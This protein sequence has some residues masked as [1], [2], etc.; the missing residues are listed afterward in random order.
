MSQRITPRF[1][2]RITPHFFSRATYLSLPFFAVVFCSGLIF[3]MTH[4]VL[5][6]G[7]A[8]SEPTYIRGQLEGAPYR[9]DNLVSGDVIELKL[10][11]PQGEQL[12]I[13]GMLSDGEFFNGSMMISDAS[14]TEV[15]RDVIASSQPLAFGTHLGTGTSDDRTETTYTLRIQLDEV[16]GKTTSAIDLTVRAYSV[17]RFDADTY[18]DAGD[19]VRF[20]LPMPINTSVRGNLAARI[21][22]G[23]QHY[24]RSLSDATDLY[25]LQ[26]LEG[27]SYTFS[28]SPQSPLAV[29][30]ALV[31]A[32]GN[33]LIPGVSGASG[34]PVS[35]E[36]T[37]AHNVPVFARVDFLDTSVG[38]E[39]DYT[40][41]VHDDTASDAAFSNT[42]TLGSSGSGLPTK[43][44]SVGEHTSWAL[45]Q[46]FGTTLLISGDIASQGFFDGTFTLKRDNEVVFE[47][48]VSGN[49][50]Q[51]F[52]FEIASG[53]DTEDTHAHYSLEYSYT[54]GSDPIQ[55]R[56][57]QQQ[58]LRVDADST[59][60]AGDVFALATPLIVDDSPLRLRN[61]FIAHGQF[62]E[63]G[64][65]KAFDDAFDFYRFS[66]PANATYTF[67]LESAADLDLS[68][69][70]LSDTATPI[71]PLRHSTDSDDA[72]FHA[73]TPTDLIVKIGI[74]A[75]SSVRAGL[76]DLFVDI[77]PDTTPLDLA[78]E[79]T[80]SPDISDLTLPSRSH[81][82]IVDGVPLAVKHIAPQTQE[83]V[84]ISVPR[85]GHLSVA[86]EFSGGEG[87]L[88]SQKLYRADVLIHEQTLEGSHAI[89]FT[90]ELAGTEDGTD[91]T[92]YRLVSTIESILG[93]TKSLT[94]SLNP[95]LTLYD[96]AGES[97][98]H[99][100]ALTSGEPA[101]GYLSSR[102][103]VSDTHIYDLFDEVDLY[104][105]AAQPGDS[106]VAVVQPNKYLGVTLA[107]E[108]DDGTVVA[109][110]TSSDS[111]EPA[112][113][114]F[115]ATT[116]NTFSLSVSFSDISSGYYGVYDITV[117]R[118]IAQTHTTSDDA[119]AIDYGDR[120]MLRYR[121][122]SDD[123]P[124]TRYLKLAVARGDDISLQTQS[125]A[126]VITSTD[127][128][129]SQGEILRTAHEGKDLTFFA[130]ESGTYLIK[131]TFAADGDVVL[132]AHINSD[133][134]L[135]NSSETDIS[136]NAD[137]ANES[138]YKKN[139]ADEND[140]HEDD[141]YNDGDPALDHGII[142]DAKTGGFSTYAIILASII[143]VVLIPVFIRTRR[144]TTITEEEDDSE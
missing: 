50:I 139:S 93:N 134:I 39:G 82:L 11:V 40:L 18:R 127:L 38:F 115:V 91:T 88:I 85:G 1:L 113:L 71:G 15:Y 65:I 22:G 99:A 60:D 14:G 17:R 52:Y 34:T 59:T 28:L 120:T 20:A 76:Y 125:D 133:A 80:K 114:S 112:A 26:L 119:L 132:T 48:A 92:S 58:E 143:A 44:I 47:E 21:G 9:F 94:L 117:S 129:N 124:T 141:S 46:R 30:L 131:M 23:Q 87:V 98:P 37:P 29:S 35:L 42:T 56:M 128:I 118:D 95:S 75:D 12:R 109:Q 73:D 45:N 41:S 79:I 10:S 49:E 89:P 90:V 100:M 67:T 122:G 130:S 27:A 74:A 51:P 140:V 103:E 116:N 31:D 81:D 66:L 135:D 61:N 110:S 43:I 57:T 142:H 137:H 70:L 86:G 8:G 78:H 19:T 4:T 16:W 138:D 136:Q 97:I 102:S 32:V 3:T 108:D 54:S 2:S 96:E 55:L 68:L 24:Y 25:S 62:T 33:E 36:Y 7:V 104:R 5:A 111:G 6:A 72:S 101:S 105:V 83:A 69:Q 77:L 126:G 13:E 123:S 53:R 84:N 64:S 121:T 63:H 107:L 144:T 106:I